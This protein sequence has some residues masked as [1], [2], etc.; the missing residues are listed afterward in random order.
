MTV[1]RRY[2][3]CGAGLRRHVECVGKSLR[4][5]VGRYAAMRGGGGRAL[6]RNRVRTQGRSHNARDGERESDGVPGIGSHGAYYIKNFPRCVVGA[7][8][9]PA[10]HLQRSLENAREQS[11]RKP[12][13]KGFAVLGAL[14]PPRRGHRHSLVTLPASRFPGSSGFRRHY[15]LQPFPATPVNKHDYES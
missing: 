15:T 3:G 6:E 5:R 4:L 11:P 2:D 14:L 12:I 1:T 8:R 7:C 10:P 9:S 13:F